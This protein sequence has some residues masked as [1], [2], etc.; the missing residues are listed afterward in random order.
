MSEKI[1]VFFD[2]SGKGK[3]KPNLMGGVAI[4]KEIYRLPDFE[5]MSQELRDGSTETLRFHTLFAL[6]I[7]FL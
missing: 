3:V 6:L 2:E 1:M 7:Q 5:L 4:P